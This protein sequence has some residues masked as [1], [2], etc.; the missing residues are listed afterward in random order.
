VRKEFE[1]ILKI[2]ASEFIVDGV[3][4]IVL[5]SKLSSKVACQF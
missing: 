3:Y 4:L 1:Q 2:R 5:T